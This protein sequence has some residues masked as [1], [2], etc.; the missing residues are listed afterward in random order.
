[1][2]DDVRSVSLLRPWLLLLLLLLSLVGDPSP[3]IV[4]F[5]VF[6][7]LLL[8]FYPTGIFA[9]VFV[10][11]FV[12]SWF[13]LSITYFSSQER[14]SPM[15]LQQGKSSISVTRHRVLCQNSVVLVTMHSRKL[16][17][18]LTLTMLCTKITINILFFDRQNM[19]Y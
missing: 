11:N 3:T 1:M 8:S 14:V 7:T 9:D 18:V 13:L 12:N 15:L 10:I 2:S 19:F 17:Q 4:A 16:H 5:V 6:V